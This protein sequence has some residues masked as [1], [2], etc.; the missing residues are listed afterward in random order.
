VAECGRASDWSSGEFR[1][2]K[3]VTVATHGRSRSDWFS[4]FGVVKIAKL[5]GDHGANT[6]GFRSPR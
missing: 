1:G 4:G 3:V 2:G 5:N 6:S